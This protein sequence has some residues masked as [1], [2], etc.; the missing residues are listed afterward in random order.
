MKPNPLQGFALLAEASS[1]VTMKPATHQC[2]FRGQL[3][4][5]VIL[6]GF[7]RMATAAIVAFDALRAEMEESTLA[8]S[9]VGDRTLP[10]ENKHVYRVYHVDVTVR[11]EYG[12]A[13]FS[14][15]R[16]RR[17]NIA[18]IWSK[19]FGSYSL[20]HG[21]GLVPCPV[22][23]TSNHPYKRV[24]WLV[25]AIANKPSERSKDLF[26]PAILS[27]RLVPYGEPRF[28]CCEILSGSEAKDCYDALDYFQCILLGLLL[29][30]FPSSCHRGQL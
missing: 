22:Q 25:K 10:H 12:E 19:C 15:P 27:D 4:H 26:S 17:T 20:S 5:L 21:A 6:G 23:R 3:R 29:L 30:F 7:L 28:C 24:A 9:E 18:S 8:T 11:S 13:C 16:C 2:R 1:A 14:R